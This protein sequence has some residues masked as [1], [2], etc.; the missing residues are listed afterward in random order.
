[1]GAGYVAAGE[2][3]FRDA[4]ENMF[5]DVV[6][7]QIM[8][9]H[10][11][12]LRLECE[13]IARAQRYYPRNAEEF[14]RLLKAKLPRSPWGGKQAIVLDADSN[15]VAASE[16]LGVDYKI[17]GNGKYDPTFSSPR[18]YGAILYRGDGR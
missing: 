4:R 3:A 14:N 11:R 7:N 17:I 5:S 15:V 18:A 9:Q 8:S 6:R 12:S 1:M 13:R 16:R 2:I 10:L